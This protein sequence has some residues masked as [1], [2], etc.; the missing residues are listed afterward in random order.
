MEN[1]KADKGKNKMDKEDSLDMIATLVQESEQIITKA[2]EAASREA[3]HELERVLREYEQRT[4]QIVL[5]VREETK[6]KIVEIANKLSEAVL[7]GI[8]R[9]STK[10][11]VGVV[12]ELSTKAGELTKKVQ[13]AVE[14]EAEQAVTGV[15]FR[16]SGDVNDNV[17][18][19]TSNVLQEELKVNNAGVEIAKEAELITEEDGIELQQPIEVDNFDEWLAQ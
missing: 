14:K 11:V 17:E 9:A 12:N 8:E 3:E 4:K 2:S 16:L 19:P 1:S 6:S 15:T 7:L 5:K 18:K 13:E 10:A